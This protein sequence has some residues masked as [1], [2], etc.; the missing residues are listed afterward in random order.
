MKNSALLVKIFSDQVDRAS[1]VLRKKETNLHRF[2]TGLRHTVVTL[3]LARQAVHTLW[4]VFGQWGATMVETTS[5]LERMRVLLQGLS[6][7]PDKAGRLADSAQQFNRIVDLSRNAPFSIDAITD[8][9]VKMKS[10]GLDP[11]NGSMQALLDATAN[12]GGTSEVLH[13]AS[14]A[15]QQMAGKGVI[16]MEELRQQLGEAIPTAMKNMADGMGISIG[17][18]VKMIGTGTV[19]AKD[20]LA[21]M[22]FIFNEEFAGS[23]ERMMETLAGSIQK[24]KSDWSLFSEQVVKDSGLY[25]AV[26]EAVQ[27]L[28]RA[29]ADPEVRMA[30]KDIFTGIAN[31]I[32]GF[33]EAVQWVW[34]YRDAIGN[35]IV[36]L[37]SF[38][39]TLKAISMMMAAM[40]VTT[41]TAA[42]KVLWTAVDGFLSAIAGGMIAASQSTNMMTAA[43]TRLGV[44]M[45]ALFAI[46]PGGWVG[47]LIAGLIAAAAAMYKFANRTQDA[48]D[49]LKEYGDTADAVMQKDGEKAVVRLRDQL[50]NLFEQ[51]E[52]I[53]KKYGGELRGAAFLQGIDRRINEVTG[54]LEMLGEGLARARGGM[55]ERQISQAEADYKRLVDG[56]AQGIKEAF[57]TRKANYD[58][59]TKNLQIDDEARAKADQA[60]RTSLITEEVQQLTS[61]YKQKLYEQQMAL[62]MAGEGNGKAIAAANVAMLEEAI[63]GEEERLKTWMDFVSRGPKLISNPDGEEDSPIVQFIR[64]TAVKLAG[65][66]AFLSGEVEK[67]E[68]LAAFD[69]RVALGGFKGATK[70][71]ID[72]ARELVVAL[73]GATDAKKYMKDATAQQDYAMN[74]L[75]QSIENVSSRYQ[76]WQR[77]LMNGGYKEE[78]SELAT[79]N[80][81]VAKLQKDLMDPAKIAQMNKAIAEAR[82]MLSSQAYIEEFINIARESIEIE[83][84]NFMTR[85]QQLEAEIELRR[86]AMEALI[87]ANGLDRE[88]A[89]S[90]RAAY[91]RLAEQKREVLKLDLSPLYGMAKT[92][93][94]VTQNMKNA[95][96][97]WVSQG[98]DAIVNF[99]MTGKLNF[100]DMAKSILADILKIIIRGMIAQSILSALGF[101]MDGTRIKKTPSLEG[102]SSGVRSGVEQNVGGVRMTTFAKGGVMTEYGMMP[103]RRYASGGIARR[104]QLALYGEGDM[105]E[106]YVPLPDGRTI[107]VTLEGQQSAASPNVMV[108]VINQTGQAVNAEQQGGPRMD[109]GRMVLD[110]V[111]KAV[112]SPGPFRDGMRSA[113][114]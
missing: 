2:T 21:R 72:E 19:E 100:A 32:R 24:L 36:V 70:A 12:F 26:K 64:N 7:A 39:G 96:A 83:R 3:G 10:G 73:S 65:V 22:M 16:S 13:R 15:L 8:S 95:T 6:D 18:L 94:D 88:Q 69:E 53:L 59:A 46:V 89:E 57:A 4:T 33:I 79:F 102:V 42:F 56:E 48:I 44:A 60:N 105:A 112:N 9:W 62:V 101:N 43:T 40:Q 74:S 93:G 109:G 91:A 35:T 86:R 20:A 84:E 108:N 54:Q 25:D 58:I 31:F 27:A 76:D 113:I 66:N 23:A 107:P 114:R 103:L 77:A 5:K 67:S 75:N 17:R 82:R 92:W 78:T 98:V 51:R 37:G 87:T 34:K 110:V 55:V 90:L 97:D 52:K 85:K 38:L 14:I 1:G 106:A 81:Q 49:K 30:V 61:L 104:P 45:K 111:L 80:A 68:E 63:K 11:A 28:G 99:A 29:L 47:L 41:L 71:Q 50:I